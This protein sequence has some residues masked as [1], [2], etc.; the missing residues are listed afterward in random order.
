MLLLVDEAQNLAPDTL[1][2]VRL[3]SNLETDTSKLIQIILIGQPELDA[4]LES[5]ELRQLRQRISVRWRLSPLSRD[6]D[7]RLRAPP[8]AH[9]GGR[10]RAR[11]SPSSRCARCTGARAASR[12]S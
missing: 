12:A 5:P 7:A 2:Q 11:S 3:L 10:E 9:R 4:I 1:E 8:P 6:R